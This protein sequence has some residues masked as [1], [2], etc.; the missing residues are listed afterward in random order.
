MTSYFA[1]P[2]LLFLFQNVSA[3][4]SEA[5]SRNVIWPLAAGALRDDPQKCIESGTGDGKLRRKIELQC[6]I[7]NET[8]S[9]YTAVSDSRMAI[10]LSWRGSVGA[11][12]IEMEALD[13]LFGQQLTFPGGAKVADFF[14]NAFLKLW[15]AGIKDDFFTLQQKYP[16]YEIWVTGH[17]LGGAMAGLCAGYLKQMGFADPSKIRLITYGEPRTGDAQYST[18]LN[19]LP[20]SYRVVHDNDW[21]P[22]VP[23]KNENYLHHGIEIYYP[24]NMTLGLPYTICVGNE[25]K[26][27]SSGAPL[28][29]LNFR[30]HTLYFGIE[31]DNYLSRECKY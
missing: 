19:S 3:Q 5:F 17:S 25:D 28:F 20:Y 9:A 13:I 4:Y 22:H 18:L 8:C 16:D 11:Y 21:I 27:C 7:L 14:Y 6:D 10:I 2:I 26:S 12:E 23:F 15:N 24:N 30:D 1:I 29:R 31:L